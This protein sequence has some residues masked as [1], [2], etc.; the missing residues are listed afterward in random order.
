[1]RHDHLLRSVAIGLAL[2][3]LPAAHAAKPAAARKIAKA[4]PSEV[5]AAR[6]R[7]VSQLEVSELLIQPRAEHLSLLREH[8]R[9]I[10]DNRLT[11]LVAKGGMVLGLGDGGFQV[12]REGG[13][14]SR[15]TAA[16]L[17]QLGIRGHEDFNRLVTG[18]LEEVASGIKGIKGKDAREIVRKDLDAARELSNSIYT[19]PAVHM[20]RRYTQN[21]RLIAGTATRDEQLVLA[22]AGAKGALVY[23]NDGVYWNDNGTLRPP[24]RA[25]LES[26]NIKTP[27]DFKRVATTRVLRLVGVKGS[28]DDAGALAK[29]EAVYTRHR[30]AVHQLE[31]LVG[32]PRLNADLELVAKSR[33]QAKNHKAEPIVFAKGEG[34]ELQFQPQNYGT[35]GLL[36]IKNGTSREA[37]V[38]DLRRFGITSPEDFAAA[39]SHVLVNETK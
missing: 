30:E 15:A 37:K 8:D 13:N 28:A 24:R 19:E 22:S 38:A 16:D 12:E 17:E 36:L 32:A 35:Q 2:S 4:K 7:L 11:P 31:M 5:D 20:I 10:N 14:Q 26:V 23:A 6:A 33:V 3:V 34:E 27:A 29:A 21:V 1:M 39:A 9:Q 25:D 18:R